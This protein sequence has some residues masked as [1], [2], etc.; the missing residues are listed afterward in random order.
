MAAEDLRYAVLID[1]ENVSYRRVSSMFEELARHGTPTV[2]RAYGDWT[3]PELRGWRDQLL[4]HALV[5]IQEFA[6]TEGKNST[7]FALVIDAMDLLYAGNVECFAIVSS[8]G[9]FTRLVTRLRESGKVV[10]G[11]G[12]RKTPAALVNACNQFIYLDR[13]ERRESEPAPEP[14]TTG[15]ASLEDP[16][17]K[18][19]FTK[20]MSEAERDDGWSALATVGQYLTRIQPSFDSRDY[21]HVKLSRLARQLPYVE[22]REDE[23]AP[24]HSQLW[25]RPKERGK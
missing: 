15:P 18:R 3:K 4:E 20:A 25:L 12:E 9:D 8:D 21:G 2:R 19:L 10:L 17:L 23:K 11:M 13:L 14:D 6:N 1:A 5:P 22:V 7:D 24:G 16:S